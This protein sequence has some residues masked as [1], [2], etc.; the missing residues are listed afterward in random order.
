M[1]YNNIG[2]LDLQGLQGLGI[3]VEISKMLG[4]SLKDNKQRL[5]MPSLM[6]A[7]RDFALTLENES[8]N[9]ISSNEYLEQAL[10]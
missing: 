1:I 10:Q 3:L 7:L 5:K 2:P 4:T 6:I 9:M 8:G